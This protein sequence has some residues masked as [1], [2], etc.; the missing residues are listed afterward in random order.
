MKF[1]SPFAVIA[2]RLSRSI[3]KGDWRTAFAALILV[4]VAHIAGAQTPAARAPMAP[5]RTPSDAPIASG[6][7]V[8]ADLQRHVLDHAEPTGAQPSD[9]G[10]SPGAIT[11]PDSQRPAVVIDS[12]AADATVRGPAIIAFRTENI[13]MMSVFIP[14]APDVSA[15][16]GGHLHVTVDSAGW[17]W[18]HTS[19][20][21][22]VVAGLLPGTH[23]VRLELADKNHR[24]L[25]A[26]TVTFTIASPPIH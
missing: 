2:S 7:L 5:Q 26:Q 17:H 18:V 11:V 3:D 4:G 12:P 19:V 23:T 24:P 8:A 15:L 20:D 13:R 1:T 9:Q 21:P 14:E 25:D 6:A 10:R 16:P 22:V